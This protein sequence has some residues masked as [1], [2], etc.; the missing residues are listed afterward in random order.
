MASNYVRISSSIGDILGIA[1]NLR[2]Q[3]RNL[4]QKL[5]P[6]LDRITE[7]EHHPDTFPMDDFTKDFKEVY[8]APVPDSG[9]L[10]TNEAVK[11]SARSMGDG[12]IQIGDFVAGA[13]WNYQGQDDDNAKDI[14]TSSV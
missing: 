13:M 11:K 8:E 5:N 9:G 2:T 6:L 3:G 10:L 7:L 4:N 14:G 1:N 12:M